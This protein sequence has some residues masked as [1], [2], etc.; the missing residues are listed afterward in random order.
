MSPLELVLILLLA[1]II[2][3]S[4]FRRL[5]LPPMLG[6]LL[7]G[8]VIGP[9]ATGLIPPDETTTDFAQ[10]GVIFLMFTVGL[11]FSLA[12]LAAMRR[13]VF[14]LGGAQMAVTFMVG[15]ALATLLGV[16][17]QGAI[18][19]AGALA[20]S[21]TAIISRLLAERLELNSPHGHRVMGVMLFQD[22]A[23]VPLLILIPELTHH[24]G[25]L[26][27]ILMIAALKAAVILAL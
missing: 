9:H 25:D 26:L 21:S 15:F 11:E 13:T 7:A 20:L 24:Q 12:Q 22:L 23:V 1:A 3:V 27:G 19:L 8:V 16:S 5:G 4:L 2:A 18:V 14:G 17:W 6:Y 10:F